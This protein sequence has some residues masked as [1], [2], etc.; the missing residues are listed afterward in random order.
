MERLTE[1]AQQMVKTG[2]SEQ[3]RDELHMNILIVLDDVIAEI[4]KHE[5][6]KRLTSLIFNRRHKI[7]NGTVSILMVAQKYSM[8]PSR[9][10]SNSNWIEVF[11]LN[12]ADFQFVYKDAVTLPMGAWEDLLEMAFGTDNSEETKNEKKFNHLGIQV[13]RDAFY[14]NFNRIVNI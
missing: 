6:D 11:K 5:F 3:D 12:P 2:L 4:K 13:E 8:I 7:V 1:E 14:L 10:R 9:L